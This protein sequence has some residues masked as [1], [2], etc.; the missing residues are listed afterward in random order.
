[1]GVGSP[2]ARFESSSASSLCK[3]F[4]PGAVPASA[5][6][7]PPGKKPN[8]RSVENF[9]KSNRGGD[10][11]EGLPAMGLKVGKGKPR[12]ALPS[13]PFPAFQQ[14]PPRARVGGKKSSHPLGP[15]EDGQISSG[16]SRDRENMEGYPRGP[17]L[18]I[19][20]RSRRPFRGASKSWKSRLPHFPREPPPSPGGASLRSRVPVLAP[21]CAASGRLR[22]HLPELDGL[23]RSAPPLPGGRLSF[24]ALHGEW[25]L[26]QGHGRKLEGEGPDRGGGKGGGAPREVLGSPHRGPS[27]P[28]ELVFRPQLFRDSSTAEAIPSGPAFRVRAASSRS[29]DPGVK[30]PPTRISREALGD[31]RRDLALHPGDPGPAR[32]VAPKRPPGRAG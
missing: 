11:P 10:G 20:R 25:R 14:P 28:G 12:R 13:R 31:S 24:S 22:G 8:L 21:R 15:Q 3:K 17:S 7:H 19:K 26:G 2:G 9:G 6:Q 16:R 32:G 27:A 1:M 18:G 5:S 23:H 29:G 4:I 30:A